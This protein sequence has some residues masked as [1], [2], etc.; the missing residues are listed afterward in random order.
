MAMT[1]PIADL[2]TRIRNAAHARKEQVDVPW[3]RVKARIVEVLTAEGYLKE[4]SVVEQDGRRILRVWLK[5][6]GQNQPVIVGL[7]RVS[8]PSLRIYVGAREI[9]AIRRGLGISIL[10]TPAGIVTDRDARKLHVGGEV[11]CSVW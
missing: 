3:S 5:Y 6:D 4:H 2:L 1:D 7:K 8:R 10:S 11:V 9:P